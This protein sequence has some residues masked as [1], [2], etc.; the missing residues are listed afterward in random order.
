MGRFAGVWNFS[1]FLAT[2]TFHQSSVGE[3]WQA[4]P[5]TCKVLM[6]PLVNC[7]LFPT[8]DGGRRTLGFPF[9]GCKSLKTRSVEERGLSIQF[10]FF[11]LTR[12]F[13]TRGSWTISRV[14]AFGCVSAT[15]CSRKRITIRTVRCSSGSL[16][17]FFCDSFLPTAAQ[18]KQSLSVH[19]RLKHDIDTSNVPSWF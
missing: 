16:A 6:S 9:T 7:R 17:L 14:F 10:P 15:N 18:I 4:I 12:V 1:H 2:G 3:S 13:I 5:C 19:T 11:V 8:S